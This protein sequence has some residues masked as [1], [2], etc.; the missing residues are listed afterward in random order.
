MERDYDYD[1]QHH[2][3]D[4]RNGREIGQEAGER[5]AARVNPRQVETQ[6]ATIIFE[7]RMART[8]VSHFAGA[9]NSSSIVRKTSFLRDDLGNR[10]FQP[11]I[12][13]IDEPGI[14]RGAASR[15]FDAE[16]VTGDDLKLIDDGE[17]TSWLLD[18]FHARELDLQTNGRANR[19]G[20]NTVPGST[21][22]TLEAG[23]L[24]RADMISSVKSGFY[25]TELI[26]QGVNLVSGDYSR[27]A[28]GFWIEN[29]ELTYA[30]SEV[31]IA[32]NLRDMFS[33]LVV[34]D[35]LDKRFG[36][37]APTVMIEDITIAGR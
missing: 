11:G 27:G 24:S 29:G 12:S 14:I 23:V 19:S 18:S 6:N 31:T 5:A 34:G 17:L 15:P 2:M 3:E 28:S 32:G 10:I 35:D 30:V 7:P 26:G 9:I 8:L 16:G 21:N 25:V 37:N 4:L 33:R 20:S 22:L 13:I 36:T 1:N